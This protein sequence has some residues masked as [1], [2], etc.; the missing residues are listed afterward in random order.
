VDSNLADV[1]GNSALHLAVAMG[2]PDMLRELLRTR[3]PV[4][5]IPLVD[6]RNQAGLTPLI[7]TAYGPSAAAGA[8]SM[9]QARPS[10]IGAGSASN[11]GSSNL[12]SIPASLQ[13][14]DATSPWA[15]CAEVLLDWRYSPADRRP[16]DAAAR[17][18]LPDSGML[19]QATDL[20]D[21]RLTESALCLFASPR[22][23]DR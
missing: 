1:G 22:V 6:A 23:C 4:H 17:S 19:L 3:V 2:R 8:S 16:S 15:Q 13:E 18:E 5:V 20:H 10:A 7:M 14:S 9:I 21:L 11:N 12:D